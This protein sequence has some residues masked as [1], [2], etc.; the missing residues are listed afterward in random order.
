MPCRK[1]TNANALRSMLYYNY[2][3]EIMRWKSEQA[4]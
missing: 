1:T 2:I 3:R 4:K